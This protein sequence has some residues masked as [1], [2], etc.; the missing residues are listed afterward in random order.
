M[1]FEG[2]WVQGSKGIL[3]HEHF[4]A[5]R[6]NPEKFGF[7]PQ[8]FENIIKNNKNKKFN[9]YDTEKDSLRYQVLEATMKKGWVRVRSHKNQYTVELY[10]NA[11]SKLPGIMK[12][13][14]SAGVSTTSTI[15]LGDISIDFYQLYKNGMREINKAL[16]KGAIPDVMPKEKKEEKKKEKENPIGIP[17]Y[18]SDKQK[19]VMMRQR[20]GQKTHLPDPDQDDDKIEEKYNIWKGIKK[21]VG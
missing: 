13:L 8:E 12:F 7:Q 21:I 11:A 1:A 4:L 15:F 3:I 17:D 19:R 16:S 14:K 5:V 18:L 6:E 2:Y 9:P 20:L 10:G